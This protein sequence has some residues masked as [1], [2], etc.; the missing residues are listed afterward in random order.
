MAVVLT[1][2]KVEFQAVIG[3]LSNRFEDVG[4]Q[5]TVY[6]CGDFDEPS[7]QSW[8]I[9][10]VECGAGNQAASSEV[11]LAINYYDPDVILFVG[12]A[13]SLKEDVNLGDVVASTKV[14]CYHSGKSAEDF[15]HRPELAL[16]NRALEQRARAT[17]RKE[18]WLRR[19]VKPRFECIRKKTEDDLKFPETEELKV[20]Q[21][22]AHVGAI[23]AGEQV[24]A[25]TD[26]GTFHRIK[27]HYNDA[28]CVEMEGYGTLK[29]ASEYG[30]NALVIRGISD[31]VDNKASYDSEGWQT[32]ASQNASAFAFEMLAKFQSPSF[33]SLLFGQK[34]EL[35]QSGLSSKSIGQPSSERIEWSVSFEGD[36]TN[37]GGDKL[38]N[39]EECLRILAEDRSLC[40]KKIETGSIVVRI[41]GSPE[42]F[43]T[44]SRLYG[45]GRLREVAGVPIKVI[46]NE[47][48][49]RKIKEIVSRFKQASEPL[50]SWPTTLDGEKWLRRKELGKVEA[51]IRTQNSSVTMVLGSPGSG[52]SALLA[53]L[54][55]RLIDQGIPVLGIKADKLNPDIASLEQLG[56]FLNLPLNPITSAR[57]LAERNKVV[58]IVDQLDALAD[59]VDLRSHRINVVLDL[60]N[61]LS[62]GSGIHIVCSCRK[63]EFDHDVRIRSLKADLLNLTMPNW[64]EISPV[65]ANRG[66]DTSTWTDR[67]IEIL[68]TPQH[69]KIFLQLFE[70]SEDY[71]V[72]ESYQSMLEKLWNL[73]VVNPGGLPGRRD[74][75]IK[76][77]S[78][79]A[80]KETLW[81]PVAQ[82]DDKVAIIINLEAE[83]ILVRSRDGM[84]VGFRHQTLFDYVRAR[85]FVGG[86]DSLA[87][88]V[89][90]RQN[91]LFVR[92]KLWSA[93][94]YL[95]EADPTTYKKEFGKLWNEENL[96]LHARFLLIEFLGQLQTPDEQETTWFLGLL[97][98]PKY[99]KKGLSSLIGNR[100]W[101]AII[102]ESHLPVYMGSDFEEPWLLVRLLSDAWPFAKDKVLKLIR[103]HWL[104]DKLKDELVWTTMERL[105][106]WN[107]DDIKI[108]CSLIN[109]TEISNRNVAFLARKMSSTAPKLA[110]KIVKAAL[111]KSLEGISTE[112]T[113]DFMGVKDSDEDS[114]ISEGDAPKA[115]RDQYRKLIED[116]SSW[117]YLPKLATFAPEAF[118]DALWPWFVKVLQGLLQKAHPYIVGY[119]SGFSLATELD[120]GRETRTEYPLVAALDRSV[121]DLARSHPEKFID[122]LE[123]WKPTEVLT[124]QRF[125]AR[126]L[127]EIAATYPVACLQFLM[128]DPRRMVLGNNED[129]HRDTKALI[130]AVVPHLTEP[131]VRQLESSLLSF[132]Y[133]WHVPE[134][135]DIKRRQRRLRYSRLHRLRL[136]KAIPLNHL[137][138]EVRRNVEREERAFPDYRDY[139]RRS[140]G[141]WIGSPMSSEEM[142]KAKNEHIL[143]LFDKLKD[144]TEWDHPDRFLQGGSIQASRAFAE[145]A[146]EHPK[147]AKNIILRMKPG[148][149]ER[150]VG[151]AVE[152]LYD[153][154]CKSEDL[155]DLIIELDKKGF[156]G[157]EFRTSV[158]SALSKRAKEGEGLPNDICSLLKNWLSGSWSLEDDDYKVV[159]DDK[160]S[161]ESI[162]WG[163][164]WTESIPQGTYTVLEALTRAL[165]LKRPMDTHGWINLLKD[166]LERSESPKVWRT[167]TW[168]LKY[169]VN[170]DHEEAKTFLESL[171]EKYPTV[172]DS[173]N[174]VLLIAHV[175]SWLPSETVR[176]FLISMRDG[177]WRFGP[178]AYAELLLLR[179]V[180]FP[181]EAWSQDALQEILQVNSVLTAKCNS[182]RLGLAYSAIHLWRDMKYRTVAT[183]IML[184]L[185]PLAEESISIALMDVF[186]V[187]GTL[188]FDKDTERFFEFLIKYPNVLRNASPDFLIDRL[189]EML[190]IGPELV[191]RVTKV[192]TDLLGDQLANISS[193]LASSAPN[194][195]NIALTLQRYEGELRQQ[196]L[197]L[198]ERLLELDVYG[199]REALTELDCRPLAMAK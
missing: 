185:L 114:G 117:Y 94:V 137:S 41:E 19:N 88:F 57:L 170:C 133:Y 96:R 27:D 87:K 186:R 86:E 71:R 106:D 1:A 131:Q 46:Y 159:Q 34:G 171:F 70:K 93:L 125:L 3:H 164:G 166:H 141:G 109:R 90:D 26:S 75:L 13:G 110:P 30:V 140:T 194:L 51:V 196:G 32:I 45:T 179:H 104:D 193:S 115:N 123:K 5:G 40:V 156:Q 55:T 24:V 22:E 163:Y 160:D 188:Y 74:L 102:S 153:S 120:S 165:L 89:I 33:S 14:Y 23:A 130:A 37:L 116:R 42:G 73:K 122:F 127:T 63:F 118:L 105:Q 155:F 7:G 67:F 17:A 48:Q 15:Y 29:A 38:R 136:L 108:V 83:G 128:D 43:R 76:M 20:R 172:K 98:V 176:K 187:V 66:I 183:P 144:E 79:M 161:L 50:I 138:P 191:A 162:L 36:S 44:I 168:Q 146:K 112:G 47:D 77:A 111:E 192:I 21:A 4:N 180:Q 184:E 81:L 58:L 198:F 16:S 147:R 113:V 135:D 178:Q 119:P 60:V 10:V 107:E 132:S 31:L 157:E 69:L 78:I 12:V 190:P 72:F 148:Y 152:A 143:N 174:G 64:E 25:S 182:M 181:D 62:A 53:K 167:F 101:F 124:V 82:F 39:I 11:H 158:A 97:D 68:L 151:Y 150:P 139:D 56:E 99:R 149:Q 173:K 126:G 84:T 95:R 80:E 85:A 49:F 175:H 92:P 154:N 2:L 100:D 195:V 18:N 59:L 61:A 52:K 103:N 169:L 145:F 189:R 54:G 129:E 9:A 28:L 134:D 8:K 65:L 35:E 177:D 197:S 91:A 6:E 142:G 199:A 121:K